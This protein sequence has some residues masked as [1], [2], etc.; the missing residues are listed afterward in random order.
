[1][2]F[3]V[4][5]FLSSTCCIVKDERGHYCCYVMLYSINLSYIFFIITRKQFSI[6][7]YDAH[8]IFFCVICKPLFPID[9]LQTLTLD[10]MNYF[11][12]RIEG[13]NCVTLVVQNF[14]Y[15]SF[16]NIIVLFSSIKNKPLLLLDILLVRLSLH[17]ETLSYIASLVIC[18]VIFT[19]DLT[20]LQLHHAKAN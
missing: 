3:I 6:H 1:M 7:L 19:R 5:C 10:F 13:G 15:P 18:S 16:N 20:S 12:F 4:L 2:C 14:K 9:I 8:S 11:C 17:T